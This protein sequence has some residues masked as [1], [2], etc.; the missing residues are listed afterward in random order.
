[1]KI[2]VKHVK[3]I[4]G[5]EDDKPTWND[6]KFNVAVNIYFW[7]NEKLSRELI[8]ADDKLR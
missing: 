1:M 2:D 3:L 4:R 6:S 5:E 8:R 7:R